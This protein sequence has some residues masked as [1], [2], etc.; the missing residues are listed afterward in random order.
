MDDSKLP[1]WKL[2]GNL[3]LIDIVLTDEKLEQIIKLT[4]SIPLPASKTYNDLA[5]V[6]E[7][8]VANSIYDYYCCLN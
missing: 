5:D 2:F 4:K 7:S 1:A 6:T 3:P 8:I